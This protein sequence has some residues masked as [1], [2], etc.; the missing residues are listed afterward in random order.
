MGLWTPARKK[1]CVNLLAYCSQLRPRHE[2]LPRIRRH[3]L[4]DQM[5][6]TLMTTTKNIDHRIPLPSRRHRLHRSFRAYKSNLDDLVR[7]FTIRPRYNIPILPTRV[8]LRKMVQFGV[9]VWLYENV[10]G[11]SRFGRLG[12]V[13]RYEPNWPVRITHG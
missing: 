13:H 2:Y 6:M 5:Q 4:P 8:P 1:T 12:C 3:R 11:C 7:K 10:E 9:L